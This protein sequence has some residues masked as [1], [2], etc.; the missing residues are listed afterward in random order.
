EAVNRLSADTGVLFVVS[1]GN[2]GPRP[3]T[4]GSPGTADAALT[5]G[6]VDEDDALATS[7]SIG[8][9][10][11]DSAVKPDLTAPG[12]DIAAA[13]AEGS[14]L[15]DGQEPV[16]EGYMNLSGTSMAAPHVAGAAALL[17]QQHPDWSGDRLKAALVASADPVAGYGAFQQG[18]GRTDVSRAVGQTVVAEPVSVGFGE[19]EWP[20]ADNEP[21]TRELT[22]RNLGTEDVTLDL[23]V[24]AVG[25]D[26]SPAPADMFRLGAD[27]VTVPAGGTAAVEATARTAL[28]ETAPIGGYSMYVTATGGGQ[29]V[30]VAGGIDL[31]RE[32]HEVTLEGIGLDGG[33]P[34]SWWLNVYDLTTGE[35]LEVPGDPA[36]GT[37]R[38]RLPADHDYLLISTMGGDG[39]SN[40]QTVSLPGLAE[41]TAVPLDARAAE[42]IDLTVPD[43]DA[44]RF[45]TF[46]NI[47]L[48]SFGTNLGWEDYGPDTLILTQHIGPALPQDELIAGFQAS[49]TGGED[50]EYHAVIERAGSQFTGHEQH[51][52][53]EDLAELRLVQGAPTEGAT[54]R[55]EVSGS[56]RGALGP[57]RDL[58]ADTTLYLT[59]GTWSYTLTLSGPGEAGSLSVYA[60]EVTAGET[61]ADVLG[62]GVFAPVV[63]PGGGIRRAGDRLDV[64]LTTVT[65][66]A[67]H[68][69]YLSGGHGTATLSY[70][71]EVIHTQD[72]FIRGWAGFD[73]PSAEGRY[74]LTTTA[75]RPDA[76]VS[77]RISATF[78]FTSASVPD[79]EEQ[80]LPVSLVRFAPALAP[81]SSAPAGQEMRVPVS[82]EGAAAGDGL[83]SLTV[84]VSYDGGGTWQ[85]T[86]VTDGGISV[87]NPAAGGSVSFRAEVA[88]RSGGTTELT[89]IDAYRTV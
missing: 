46:A 8:P 79:G 28:D 43:P 24:E 78:G 73:V 26:G 65:D 45:Y 30:G 51:F 32:F 52:T 89:L 2:D 17:A 66:G 80:V 38:L 82:V 35:I 74:E 13:A 16:A 62:V 6:S 86:P 19:Q 84:E 36:D 69:A 39:Y 5:V 4:L 60:R 71:G 63:P 7:S 75:E 47:A 21:V 70:D 41:D 72:D 10:L 58:P 33:M 87:T 27:T 68:Q 57:S 44:E 50:A 81:D 14:Y 1:A 88:D 42:P 18:A 49:W 15:A 64:G 12:V 37:W 25:P 67:G 3:G 22:Y 77:T 29:S 20:H 85:E 76:G 23:S 34:E 55:L 83:A 31:L 11:G 56:R 54:G 59:G 61:Y 9:R 40:R 48:P 53:H